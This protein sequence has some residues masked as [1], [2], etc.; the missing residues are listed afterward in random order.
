ML[1]KHGHFI[2]PDPASLA[3][4]TVC[5]FEKYVKKLL[6]L[7]E[8]VNLALSGGTA[9]VDF[10]RAI[11]SADPPLDWNRIRFFWSDERCVPP[12][13]PDSN[14]GKAYQSFLFPLNIS[15]SNIFRIR[16][17]EEP[18]KEAVRY[19]GLIQ[20]ELDMGNGVPS[21]DWLL[22]GMGA[23]GHTLSIFP[24]QI[25]LYRSPELCVVSILPGTD[26]KRI[27]FTGKLI[28]E[29]K[30]ITFLVKGSDKCHTLKK[31]IFG[32]DTNNDYPASLINSEKGWI[33]WYLD[34]DAAGFIS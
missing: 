11:A 22:L 13:H 10:Y 26:Q 28:K 9:A 1:L 27:T 6:E 16:G 33:D 5:E 24:D 17:E 2:Y 20:R 25:K 29:A 3:V 7:K 19:A 14:Y 18:E 32:K 30:R 21:F 31:V 4:A 34:K 15:P 23:D 12:N 8:Y